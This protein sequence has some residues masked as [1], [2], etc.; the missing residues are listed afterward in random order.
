MNITYTS[1]YDLADDDVDIIQNNMFNW[2]LAYKN[3][4]KIKSNFETGHVAVLDWKKLIWSVSLELYDALLYGEYQLHERWTLWV[5]PT[6]RGLKI[7]E[8]LVQ[9]MINQHPDKLMFGVSKTPQAHAIMKTL[10]QTQMS[11]SKM[12]EQ[13]PQLHRILKQHG[14][15]DGFVAYLNDALAQ[16][17]TTYSPNHTTNHMVFA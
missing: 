15:K 17:L 13:Q 8:T 5:N 11:E 6:Y 16:T 1:N 7:G 9:T 4:D 10:W 14:K 12:A 2:P 3:K